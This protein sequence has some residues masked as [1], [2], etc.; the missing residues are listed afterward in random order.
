MSTYLDLVNKVIQEGGSEL[1]ELTLGT[2]GSAE[3]GRRLYPRIK[4]Q[5]AESWKMLQ[6]SR[7]EWEF[8]TAELTTVVNPRIKYANGIT[9]TVAP[10]VGDQFI[11]E[12][13]GTTIEITKIEPDTLS[14]DFIDGG[15]FGQIE[16]T[17]IGDGQYLTLGER[18]N[19]TLLGADLSFEYQEKGSYDFLAD[20][21]GLREPQWATFVAGRGNAYPIA[22]MYVPWEN[23]VYKSYSFVGTSQSVPAYVSQDPSGRIVFYPQP[24]APFTI[25]FWYDEAPGALVAPDDVPSKLPGEYHDWIA[26]LALMSIARFDKN[27]DLFE[28]ASSQAKEYKTRAERN[29]MP[30]PSFQESKF[31]RDCF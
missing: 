3:A 19:D 27:P 16:F 6:M 26:W 28:W 31:N 30:I 8:N 1:T 25:N 7:N 20:R 4:R 18:L 9:L 11:G 12:E 23:W 29:L 22:V 10:V 2:W 5:V 24:L 14:P 17:V 13:S 15:A 21:P